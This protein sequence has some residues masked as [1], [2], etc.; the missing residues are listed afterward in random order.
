[1]S[2]GYVESIKRILCRCQRRGVR[3]IH[4]TLEVKK[5]VLKE[6]MLE[7]FECRKRKKKRLAE[8]KNKRFA[9]LD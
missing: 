5:A 2:A 3:E 6:G 1:M 7:Y 8:E 9:A 4:F